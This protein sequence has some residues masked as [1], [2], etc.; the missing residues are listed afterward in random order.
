MGFCGLYSASDI[1][2]AKLNAL[3]RLALKTGVISFGM[4]LLESNTIQ[5]DGDSG[6]TAPGM[7]SL[8]VR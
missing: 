6:I 4:A 7:L 8:A 5:V 1:A 2:I 3:L